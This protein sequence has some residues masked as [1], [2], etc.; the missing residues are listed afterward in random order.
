[1]KTTLTKRSS[2]LRLLPLV[3]TIFLFL[4]IPKQTFAQEHSFDKEEL[5]NSNHSEHGLNGLME[6]ET[7]FFRNHSLDS[8][9]LHPPL[10]NKFKTKSS[11]VR[12]NEEDALKFN[13]LYF[14]IQK[15]KFS[16]II[17]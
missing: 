12:G 2:V 13:F 1:M 16:D 7:N 5:E 3:V 9:G 6:S 8:T 17:E 4:F 10:I 15:F 11:E 14:I